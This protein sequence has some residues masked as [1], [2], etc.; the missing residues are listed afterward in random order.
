MNN[1][2]G[3]AEEFLLAHRDELACALSHVSTILLFATQLG[4]PSY[5]YYRLFG[6]APQYQTIF[7][8]IYADMPKE[9]FM[10]SF[11]QIPEK[12]DLPVKEEQ[13]RLSLNKLYEVLTG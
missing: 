5:T 2:P 3:S 1:E 13:I 9:F 11:E 8:R 10:T 4:I 6:F 7:D 12:Y